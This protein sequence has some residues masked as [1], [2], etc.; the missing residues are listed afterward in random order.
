M[1]TIAQLTLIGMLGFVAGCSD[2]DPID[3]GSA[4]A[5]LTDDAGSSSALR[6]S[7][8]SAGMAVSQNS[9]SGTF[10]S[11]AQV[12]IS[13]EGATWVDLGSPASAQVAL[14]SSGDETTVHANAV[15]PAGTYTRVRLILSGGEANIDA[16][17]VLGGITF[18]GSVSMSVGGTDNE[19][20]IEKTVDPFTVTADSHV[21]ILFDLNSELWVNQQNA[22]DE[23]VEDEEVEDSTTADRDVQQQPQN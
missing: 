20:V 5:V 10:S 6:E 11:D 9:F 21:R 8:S 13:A 15:V 4:S 2:N 3:A 16:G 19:V 14:Q 1:K 7:D 18:T 23:E 22:E 17:A 12:S